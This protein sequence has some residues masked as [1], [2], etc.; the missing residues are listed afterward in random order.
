MAPDDPGKKCPNCGKTISVRAEECHYCG[1]KF[2][3]EKKPVCFCALVL[4]EFSW[5]MMLLTTIWVTV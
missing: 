3:S 5:A 1:H 2:E 4:M